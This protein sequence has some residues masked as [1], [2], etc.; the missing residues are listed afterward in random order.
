M[1]NRTG[2]WIHELVPI[3]ASVKSFYGKAWVVYDMGTMTVILKSYQTIVSR[4]DLKTGEGI[5]L[6]R[7]S[8]TTSRHQREFERQ[9][10]AG[11]VNF[12]KA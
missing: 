6:G 12:T 9:F 1:S 3:Y 10:S 11:G 5:H 4:V 2:S 7:F 8:M